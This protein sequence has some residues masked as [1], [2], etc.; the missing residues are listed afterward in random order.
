MHVVPVVTGVTALNSIVPTIPNCWV[1]IGTIVVADPPLAGSL[2]SHVVPVVT[3]VTVNGGNGIAIAFSWST[4]IAVVE[5]SRL[6]F[7]LG[8]RQ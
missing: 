3:R 2:V 7:E 6:I 5:T 8:D 4:T 1:S